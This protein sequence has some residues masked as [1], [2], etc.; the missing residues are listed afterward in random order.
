[1]QEGLHRLVNIGR[2]VD[3]NGNELSGSHDPMALF[4]GKRLRHAT[5]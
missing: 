2:F 1:M 3:I 5:S 4:L